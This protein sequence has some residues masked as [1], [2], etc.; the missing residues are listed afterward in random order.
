MN[1]TLPP[2]NPGDRPV[3]KGQ[4]G[5][6]RVYVAL[7]APAALAI[8]VYAA[9]VESWSVFALSTLI[10]ACA[11]ALGAL[12][13]F[14]FGIPQYFAAS[15]AHGDSSKAT[16]QPNTNLTQVSDWLTKI[17]IGVGLVQF[18]QLTDTIGRLGDSL[19]PS[20]GGSSTGKAFGIALVVGFFVI[21]FLVGY[22]YT[23]LR[24]QW[25]FA[26]ADR[27]AFE[28]AVKDLAEG[29]AKKKIDS[30]K[31]ADEQALKLL[32]PAGEKL[33]DKQLKEVLEEASPAAKEQVRI[34]AQE[35]KT[36]SLAPSDRVDAVLEAIDEADRE[37]S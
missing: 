32:D 10:G 17:I 13:G 37:Q 28:Q 26:S 33:P 5:T 24:L 12:L 25:A 21:G 34:Q 14:L 16:Y 7:T 2:D 1:G 6:L 22:L 27:A 29:V 36:S 20:L 3:E 23:R 31:K 30:Q 4:G 35:K 19:E 15:G 18:G 8:A 11:F 9:A